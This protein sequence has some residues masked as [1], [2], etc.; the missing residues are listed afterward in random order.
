M[1]L[2]VPPKDMTTFA[3]S[4][5][6]PVS[7]DWIS[8]CIS[9][10]PD[11][12]LCAMSSETVTLRPLSWRGWQTR[13]W[14]RLLSGTISKPLTANL[15]AA[16]FISS[17]P[18][19]PASP[20]LSQDYAKA[21]TIPAI[22]GPTSPASLTKSPPNGASLKTFP[23]ISP[24]VCETSWETFNAW[25]IALLRA[26]NLRL[27]SARLTGAIVSSYWPT[28]T[29]KGSGNRACILVGPEGLKFRPDANQTGKQV[30]I[31]N[32][33]SAWT[34][35]W[36]IMIASGWTP[37]PFPSSHRVRVNLACGEKRSKHG[38]TLNPAFSDWMMGWPTGWTDPLQPV[39]AWSHWL[40]QG[41]LR[42]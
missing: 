28:P 24:L 6:A 32:A 27:K 2:F 22:S 34:L 29:F 40:Q 23:A 12:E 25:A 36:D 18:V 31:R 30:G 26:S 4:A 21:T 38:P 20:S 37:A 19:I 39:T 14:A 35:F 1:W 9:Q 15:G 11:I 17:L 10:N 7:A 33:T 42:C 3:E 41:R 8:D 13:P 5:F 16:A